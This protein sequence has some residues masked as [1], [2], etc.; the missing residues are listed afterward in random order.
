MAALKDENIG[1]SVLVVFLGTLYISYR[2]EFLAAK[3]TPDKT[4]ERNSMH[5]KDFNSCISGLQNNATTDVLIQACSEYATLKNAHINDL[6][7][8]HPHSFQTLTLPP[9][10]PH[11]LRDTSE[12]N[13]EMYLM[14]PIILWNYQ[15]LIIVT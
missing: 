13:P 6:K 3:Y 7:K 9:K 4:Q 2:I 11:W 1:L 5:E 15:S 10:V 8:S 12:E 14:R